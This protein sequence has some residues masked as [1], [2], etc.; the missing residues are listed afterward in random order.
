[1]VEVK[2]EVGVGRCWGDGES[3]SRF[4]GGKCWGGGV[5][6]LLFGCRFRGGGCGVGVGW[7]LGGGR[8][9]CASGQ[10]LGSEGLHD[11]VPTLLEGLDALAQFLVL[12]LLCTLTLLLLSL[13]VRPR[14]WDGEASTQLP[15]LLLE[16]AHTALE[17]GELRLSAVA[18][19]LGCD[20]VAVSSGLLAVLS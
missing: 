2:V 10:P 15:I 5:G 20:A 12:A 3:H 1:V 9:G 14:R 11:G 18:G 6:G 13:L 7:G 4:K 8:R 19:V 16:L 17:V